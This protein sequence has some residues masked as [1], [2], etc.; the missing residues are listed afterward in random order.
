MLG[1]VHGK[2][3]LPLF[4]VLLDKAGNSNVVDRIDLMA[5]FKEAFPDQPIA[6]LTADREFMAGL[7]A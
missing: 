1:I 6:S 3:C 2:V 4:W 5:K 7:V